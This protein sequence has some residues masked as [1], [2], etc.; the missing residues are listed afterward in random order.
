MEIILKIKKNLLFCYILL[1]S[2]NGVFAQTHSSI[3]IDSQ[4]YS[5]LE[6]AETR[7]LCA[8]LSGVRPYTQDVVVSAIKEILNQEKGKKISSTEREILEMYLVK[9]AKPKTGI[10]WRKGAYYGETSIGKI[11]FPLSLKAGITAEIEGSAGFYLQNENYFGME[12][13]P[14]IYLKGDIG[15]HVSY[16]FNIEG[17]L[18]RAPRDYLG[19]YD[20][21]Y[22][23]FVND[24]SKEFQNEPF[25]VYSEPLTHFPYTYNKRWDGS[26]YFLESLSTFDSWPNG[27][28]GGYNILSE[29]TAS[30][31]DN[32]LLMRLGRLRRDWGSVPSGSS[33]A[34]NKMARPFIGIESDFSPVPWFGFSSLAGILEYSNINGIKESAESFQNAFSITMM[35]FRFKN[36]IYL[37]FMDAVVYP[38]RFELGYISPITNSFFYQNN[39][40]DFDNLAMSA[41]LKFQYPGIGNIWFSAFLDEMTLLSDILTLD[42]QMFTLQ[43]G[44]TFYLPVLSFTSVKLSYT[45]VNPY[46]YTHNRNINP[47][48][49]DIQM[50]TAYVNNGVSLGYYLPP[51]SD[52]ILVKFETMP[53]KNLTAVLQYQM[54]RHGADFGPNS[55]DGSNLRSELDPLDRDSNQVLKRFFL[56]D[57]AYQWMHII[58]L[59]GEWVI[60]KKQTAPVSF[61]FEAGAVISYFTNTEEP[62]NS[63]ESRPYS[64][65]DTDSYP[66]STGIIIKLGFRLFPK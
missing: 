18:M 4:I 51:N 17:G 1:F 52:E 66:K 54:I 22:K 35:R 59:G 32:K 53:V 14:G 15:N 13:W 37:D 36:Y 20:N 9:Y 44:M 64:I 23:D 10:D 33:L 29:M 34:F 60:A 47:W 41:N 21:Y 12:I 46:C 55:V 48:Y 2:L 8:P 40:G 30:Y 39:I 24:E 3:H 19:K 11:D 56:H 28:A 38:K 26:V 63:G 16:D 50:E 49:G 57:G 7:G 45:K 6:L 31:L 42:R 27:I 61:Y 62:S 5:I 65:V 43:A 25:D 58:K